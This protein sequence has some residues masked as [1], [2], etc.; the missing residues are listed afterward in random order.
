MRL[1]AA[2]LLAS[3]FLLPPAALAVDEDTASTLDPDFVA[4]RKALADK[5]WPEAIKALGRVGL[6]EPNNAD[7]QNL[8]GFAW[9]NQGK[10]NVAFK[11]YERALELNPYHQGA[12]EYIGEAYLKVGDLKSAEKH[13]EV[14]RRLCPQ[15]CE[16]LQD[17]ER[18]VA[19]YRKGK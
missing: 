2:A 10:Y 15:S 19:E 11:H 6:R 14:L 9:R 7:V 3:A 13:L 18:E 8:L 16:A 5:D 1:L 17:L 12:H 4:G